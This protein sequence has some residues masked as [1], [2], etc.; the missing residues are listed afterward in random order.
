MTGRFPLSVP[1]FGAS[2][3]EE[4]PPEARLAMVLE[5]LP[6]TLPWRPTYGLS[7][8][9]LQG[10]A[11]TIPRL[12][13]AR[14]RV[15]RAIGEAFPEGRLRRCDLRVVREGMEERL[16]RS[17][18]AAERALVALGTTARLEIDVVVELPDGEVLRA[19][20]SMGEP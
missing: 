1:L 9:E 6:G 14:W 5:T 12:A 3:A 2:S 10:E 13:A 16:D 8:D 20:A 4:P 18:P 11:L 19:R 15:E 7:L 17:I